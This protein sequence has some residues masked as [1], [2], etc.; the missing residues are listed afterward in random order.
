MNRALLLVAMVLISACSNTGVE[1]TIDK[2]QRIHDNSLQKNFTDCT[3]AYFVVQITSSQSSV[4]FIDTC[5]KY[6]VGDPVRK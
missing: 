1:L 6:R 3:C 4:Y 2:I 5:N